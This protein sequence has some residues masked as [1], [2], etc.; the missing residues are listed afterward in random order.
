[1][2]DLLN[3]IEELLK[4]GPPARHTFFQLKYFVIGKEP[5]IQARIHR[6]LEE[7]KTRKSAL[8]SLHL[9]IE[10]VRER[11]ESLAT[12]ERK[13]YALDKQLTDLEERARYLEEETLFF[14]EA[15][16][17]LVA[18]EPRK[19]WDDPNVQLEYW[20]AKL[21]SEIRMRI[22]SGQPIDTKVLETALALPDNAPIKKQL[23]NM[24]EQKNKTEE[25]K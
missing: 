7:M 23:I 1:M 6:C 20:N 8:E 19:N 10:E 14:Y 22:L 5:T 17:S 18:Q 4:S 12:N 21:G 13:I 2:K 3:K 16:Q 24:I 9:E 25:N 15:Y 11:K